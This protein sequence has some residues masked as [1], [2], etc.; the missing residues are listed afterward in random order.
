MPSG[1]PLKEREVA[2]HEA[3]CRRMKKQV[4]FRL[5]PSDVVRL[6]REA[7]RAKLTVQDYLERCLYSFWDSTR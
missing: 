1:H 4:K 5:R 3:T 6:T 7:A 2:E